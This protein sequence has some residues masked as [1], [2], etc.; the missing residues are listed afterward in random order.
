[1]KLKNNL[2][3]IWPDRMVYF[4]AC[5]LTLGFACVVRVIISEAVRSAFTEDE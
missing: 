5:V 4:G 3:K 2:K 1:M